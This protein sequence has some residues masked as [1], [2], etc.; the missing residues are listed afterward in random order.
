MVEKIYNRMYEKYYP[1]SS[2]IFVNWSYSVMNAKGR[3]YIISFIEDKLNEGYK[4]KS[5]YIGT[6]IRDCHDY[7]IF[8]KK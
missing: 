3:D 4:V 8:Y 6:S 1:P 2:S 7:I 5:G